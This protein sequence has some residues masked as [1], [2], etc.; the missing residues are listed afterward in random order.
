MPVRFQRFQIQTVSWKSLKQTGF[1]P[2]KSTLTFYNLLISPGSTT[3]SIW[4]MQFT[5]INTTGIPG[6]KIDDLLSYQWC[7]AK[8]MKNH[9]PC[10]NSSHW[11][12][13]SACIN[14]SF[15]PRFNN[16]WISMYCSC[17]S[18]L[19]RRLSVKRRRFIKYC[20][21]LPIVRLTALFLPVWQLMP[22]LTTSCNAGCNQQTVLTV[23]SS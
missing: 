23:P 6:F 19:N 12:A 18:F 20:K 4:F 8:L 10:W 2:I 7:A 13:R 14:K 11:H 3:T 21:C 1:K 22:A 15:S 5:G 9:P 16:S 17:N